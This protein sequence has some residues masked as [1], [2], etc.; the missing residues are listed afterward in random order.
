MRINALALIVGKMATMGLGF[1]VW[2]VAA[3]LFSA[4]DVGLASATVSA[5]ML[6]VQLGLFGAGA[7]VI[8]LLPLLPQRRGE[9]LDSAIS[10]IF[11]SSLVAG[12]MFL[13]F[14]G[15]MLQELR[16]VAM[17]PAYATAFLAMC[18]FGTLG[19]LLDQTATALQRG[20]QM[21]IRNTLFGV[22]TLVMLVGLPSVAGFH[23]PL[24]ILMAWVCGGLI[25]TGIGY[26]QLR[27]AVRG[28]RFRGRIRIDLSRKLVTVGMPNWFLTLVERAPGAVMPIVVTELLSPETNSA[29]YAAWMIAWVVYVVPIQIGLSEFAEASHRPADLSTIVWQ[30]IRLS[31]G[32]GAV[33]ASLAALLGP[34][35]LALL[36]S[37]YAEM[38]TT[39]LR[40]LVMVA[41]PF[42]FVQAYYAV[43]RA[44]N[45]LGEAIV[46]GLVSGSVGVGAAVMA[47]VVSGVNGMALAW[48]CTQLL[49]GIAA[50][51][52][53][54]VVMR[55]IPAG[56]AS[57]V[58]T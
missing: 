17:R 54:L 18:V 21:L 58:R 10:F 45:Q 7:A 30:G 48:L 33:V 6:C 37:S 26:T 43:C 14:A 53:L 47:G 2:L 13:L 19:V 8:V 16:I 24:T 1:L 42:A 38:G 20:D 25:G 23:A 41:F 15:A 44:R 29:W 4:S 40:L 27:Q 57:S 3:R 28:Y 55:R 36:G 32:V 11:V 35:M 51:A 39:P 46:V 12:S 56:P 52:R 50:F 34:V 5:M 31:L 49:T 22:V 9:L